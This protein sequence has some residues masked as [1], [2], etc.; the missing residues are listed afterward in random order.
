[1]KQRHSITTGVA[2]LA[3]QTAFPIDLHFVLH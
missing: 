2:V 3:V 1:M